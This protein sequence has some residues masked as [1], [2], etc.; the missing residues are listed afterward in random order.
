MLGPKDVSP[1]A[2]HYFPGSQDAGMYTG[3]EL[4]SFWD[5]IL[6]SAASRNALKKFSQKLIVFSNNNKNL[7]SFLYYA[8][9]T[10]FYVDNMVSAGYFKDLFM[11]T[12]GPVAYVL[13]H[14]GIYFSMFQFFKLFIDVVV[15]VIRH[16]EI[17]KMTGASLGFG[18]TLLSA[19]YNLFLMSVLTSM[20]DPRAP[21]LAAVE[22]E[23][24][25]LCNAQELNDIRDDTQKED[26]YIYPVMS[27]A[28]F[29]QGITPISPVYICLNFFKPHYTQSFLLVTIVLQS[30]PT[31][32]TSNPLRL[33]VWISLLTLSSLSYLLSL[34]PRNCPLTQLRL[35]RRLLLPYRRLIGL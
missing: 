30:S 6:I 35:T 3:S 4:S 32:K 14:C 22:E 18:K 33:L 31:Q 1:V 19:S 20:Y 34:L 16:L 25:T 29:N 10:D 8:L 12:F 7:D 26:D 15:M 23:R 21:T 2:V 11:D 27:P 17:T 9:Q 13:E 28:Q 24:K 5:S